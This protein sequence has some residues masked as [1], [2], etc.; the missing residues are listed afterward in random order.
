MSAQLTF[1]KNDSPEYNIL[2][3]VVN[4]GFH[5]FHDRTEQRVRGIDLYTKEQSIYI[6]Y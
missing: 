6:N 3:K 5:S 4:S 2:S 1:P